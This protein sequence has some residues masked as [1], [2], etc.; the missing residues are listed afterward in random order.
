[1]AKDHAIKEFL[2]VFKK[3]FTRS[4][5]KSVRSLKRQLF[6]QQEITSE[7]CF[8]V[9]VII[10]NRNRFTFL[11]LMVDQLQSFGYKNI[12]ILDNDSSYPPLLEY[13]KSVNAKVIFLKQ[14]VGYKA[15]WETNIFEQFKDKYYVYSDPDIL[16]QQDCPK[17][18]VYQ[19]YLH[20]K[21]YSGKEKAGMALKIDDLPDTYANKQ[22]A[23]KNESIYWT[24]ELE[25]D[26]YDAEVDTTLALYKPLAFGNAEEC[27]A[28]RV[29]GKL[30]AQHLTWYLDSANLPEE[31]LY[32]KSSIK[33]NTS[34]YS[35]K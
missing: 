18:F 16:L 26:V 33:Q 17:D 3:R 35:V 10:N 1:M 30:A 2:F 13:Y 21:K 28:I 15:L 19:L 7:N 25:K 23:I 34:V 6:H 8:E 9:P 32:Y 14:N 29:G 12:Y 11:K 22:E 31:E 4:L 24:R 20:L 5:S 27:D